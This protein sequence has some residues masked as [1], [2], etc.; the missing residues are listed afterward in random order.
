MEILVKKIIIAD[1]HQVIIFWFFDSSK[2]TIVDLEKMLANKNK[3]SF[4]PQ[5][6][7]MHNRLTGDSERT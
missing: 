7:K 3:S 6:E 1:Y 4:L 5:T 2:A